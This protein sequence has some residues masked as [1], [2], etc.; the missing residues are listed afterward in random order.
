[1]P[2]DYTV[3]TN[4]ENL[5]R[6]IMPQ[7]V[8]LGKRKRVYSESEILNEVRCFINQNGTTVPLTLTLKKDMD[9]DNG[10]RGSYTIRFGSKTFS[11]YYY[12][13]GVF[14]LMFMI[15]K[16]CIQH[17]HEHMACNGLDSVGLYIYVHNTEN[18]LLLLSGQFELK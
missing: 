7:K 18:F 5:E 17:G 9:M 1:M 10:L 8:V 2:E 11:N 3:K 15:D 6:L 13:I 14:A 4:I 16:I 12:S